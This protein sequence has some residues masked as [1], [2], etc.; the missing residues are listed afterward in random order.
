[1]PHS[2][3]HST[4]PYPQPLCFA[5]PY[6]EGRFDKHNNNYGGNFTRDPFWLCLWLQCHGRLLWAGDLKGIEKH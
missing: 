4:P 5:E 2:P 1:M 6:L 3:P